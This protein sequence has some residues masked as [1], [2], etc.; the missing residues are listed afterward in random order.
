MFNLIIHYVSV[1]LKLLDAAFE[2]VVAPY[3]FAQQRALSSAFSVPGEEAARQL[4]K[5]L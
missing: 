4:Q 2:A 5:F 3:N 1:A